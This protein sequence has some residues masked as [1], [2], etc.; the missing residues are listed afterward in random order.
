MRNRTSPPLSIRGA[1]CSISRVLRRAKSTAMARMRAAPFL[2]VGA[3]TDLQQPPFEHRR[4][5]RQRRTRRNYARLIYRCVGVDRRY[6][7]RVEDIVA[8]SEKLGL[9]PL[10]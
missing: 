8:F 1:G 7:P 9:K 4:Y 6:V 10:V 3:N 5:R 2:P